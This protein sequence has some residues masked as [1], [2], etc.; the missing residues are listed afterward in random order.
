LDGINT[1]KYPYT[2]QSG[3]S[4]HPGIYINKSLSLIGYGSSLPQI[5]CSEG[6]GLVFDGSKNA[7]E[8][9]LR[10]SGL[11]FNESAVR[12][13]DFSV[14]MDD[15]AFKG[16]KQGFQ[17]VITTN[18]ASGIEIIN[19]TFSRNRNCISVV[20][21]GIRN[22]SQDTNVILKL[23]N[24]TFDRNIF[25]D[26]G[27]CIS[28]TEPPNRTN[29]SVNTN[30]ALENVTF[31]RNKF[32]SRG[33]VYF[34][35][36]NGYQNIH[37][38]NV[39][40]IDN[41]PLSG[42]DSSGDSECIIRSSAVNTVINSSNFTSEAARSFNVSA[43]N[44]SLQ[45]FHSSFVGH[46]VVGNGGVIFLKGTDLCKLNV[47]NSSFVNTTAAQGGAI[48]IECTNVCSVSFQ[49][50]N[51]TDNTARNGGGGAVYIFSPAFFSDNGE[52]ATNDKGELG[53][54]SKSVDQLLSV[55]IANC[56]FTFAYSFLEGGA[57]CIYAVKASVR[58]RHSAFTNCTAIDVDGRGGGGGGGVFIYSGLPSLEQN[59][60]NDL[61]LSVEGSHF[62]GCTSDGPYLVGGS[63]VAFYKSQVEISI[64][65]CHFISNY[66]GAVL[67]SAHLSFGEKF[68]NSSLVTIEN[69]TFLDNSIN[70]S[71]KGNQETGG[72][73]CV[74]VYNQS[75][76]V[77]KEVTMKSNRVDGSGG[78]AVVGLNC[79]LKIY[80]SRFLQ[81]KALGLGC[82]GAIYVLDINVLQVQN[83]LFDGNYAQSTQSTESQQFA[84]GGALCIGYHSSISTVISILNTNFSNCSAGSSGGV[85]YLLSH[86]GNLRLEV[87]RTRFIANLGGAMSFSLAPDTVKN[88][89]CIE[90]RTASQVDGAKE[91]PSWEYK[92]YLTFEDTTF[93]RNAAFSGGALHLRNGKSI[94][95]N[96]SFIDNFAS[97]LGGHIHTEAGSASI[98]IQ[99]S[100]FRQTVKERLTPHAVFSMASFIHSEGSGA[101]ILFNTI[102][103]ATPYGSAGP[104]MLVRNGRLIDLGNNNF[105]S[106][107]C[108]VGSEMKMLNFTD[109]VTTQ[110][111]NKPCKIKLS[112]LQ[113]SCS[114]CPVNSYSLQRGHALGS[115]ISPGFQCLP[116]PFGAD[117]SQNIIAELNFWGFKEKATPPTLN[118]TMCP[119][120]YCRPPQK[121]DFPEYNACQG[122]R[123]GT[124]CGQCNEAYTETLYS[125]TCRP[126]NECKDDWFWPVALVYVSLMA[127][128]FTFK[129]PIVPWIKR[130]ILWFKQS[131]PT[132][133]DK[134]FDCGYLKIVFYFYQA[135]NLV[136]V[137]NSAQHIFKTK[138]IGPFAG[139]FNFQQKFSPSGL[140]CP[141]PG[142]TAVTKQLFSASQVLGT[143][144]MIGVF[145]I[146]HVGVKKFRGQ[147]IPSA[148]PYIGGILQTMLLGYTGLASVSF[149]LLRCVPF[150]SEKRL[151]YDGNIVCF[152]WWQHIFIAFNCTFTVPFVFVLLWGSFKLY[153]RTIS[154]GEFLLACCLP[155]PFL[156]YWAYVSLF[157]EARNA[158]NQESPSS[159]LSRNSV[160]RVLYDCFKR[161]GD[162][163]KLSL[164]WEGVMIGRRLILIVL[165]AFISDPMPR[166]LTMSFFC[167]LFLQHHSMTQPFRDGIANTV[168]TISLL[169][170]LLL[171]MMNMFFASFVSLAVKLNEHF[172]SWWKA[173]Q[174]V[175]IAILCF[176]PF[177]FGLLVVIFI[178]SQVCR[179]LFHLWVCF[180]SCCRNQDEEIR[181]LLSASA[182]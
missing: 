12:V 41:L 99:D 18:L 80:Q 129:P 143:F 26:E 111:N 79:T 11:F 93:E 104:L 2:C 154:V 116:C 175:E 130:Q 122:N 10:L 71:L 114:T 37:L 108:P 170:I 39:T 60:D 62:M 42:A 64:N 59:L 81:N 34:K 106:L 87:K 16:S 20:V 141:F 3:T 176:V 121:T 32:S 161:P 159:Q 123:S 138:L 91:T 73:I 171:G 166:L 24:S 109:Q 146:L 67:I 65:N 28:F 50:N 147:E 160:E 82:G 113:F 128:Y 77:L 4:E 180:S 56:D 58:L 97:T 133:E 5:R 178:V 144:L 25:S 92:S 7:K 49:G 168:E 152:Q 33:L 14:E 44:V 136:L 85:L 98:V 150:G 1:D 153:S 30:M 75:I 54:S 45:I 101:L 131:K 40:F 165:K 134:S 47:S 124:V 94:F 119:L 19:S 149:N 120:G 51:F 103:D 68:T 35:I 95:R 70:G 117:C 48:N 53:Y 31:F 72:A 86:G 22:P 156:L 182:S 6:T 13:Q 23:A 29:H 110:V 172:S 164:S 88:P 142:L 145:F 52:E 89:G 100:I 105:T 27:T 90:E 112:T 55:D 139:L 173:C 8:M 151:F 43:S 38:Q 9:T 69:S 63:L 76:V 169:F 140:I 61:F 174:V 181:S 36:D 78:A 167:A 46:S 84:L 118:F 83:S 132:N 127:L 163:S 17:F 137:S 179:L 66:G 135:A 102:M 74:L 115:Q 157:C 162:G 126:L 158:A 155:L 107:N 148:A 21:T 57:V 177:A 125:T 96:C 15:C